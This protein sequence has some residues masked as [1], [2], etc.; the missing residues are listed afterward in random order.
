[1]AVGMALG[2]F[3]GAIHGKMKRFVPPK[4]ARE[5]LE[6]GP[7]Q[8]GGE[9]K[10]VLHKYAHDIATGL[11]AK[12]KEMPNIGAMKFDGGK[13]AIEFIKK[14]DPKNL[15][16]A[17]PQA[18]E[19]MRNMQRNGVPF[20]VDLVGAGPLGKAIEFI[21]QEFGLDAKKILETIKIIRTGRKLLKT[22]TKDNFDDVI[23]ELYTIHGVMGDVALGVAEEI[24]D[25]FYDKIGMLEELGFEG[26]ARAAEHI[27]E[28]EQIMVDILMR[29]EIIG[30]EVV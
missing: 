12:F 25:R 17:I 16:G 1:M 15:A 8:G 7:I 4:S 27:K 13:N 18:L 14:I 23:S 2:G 26:I 20:L 19:L 30:G 28:L 10:E 22:I 9:F 3:E 6:K 29:S 21:T 24:L 11:K 5:L